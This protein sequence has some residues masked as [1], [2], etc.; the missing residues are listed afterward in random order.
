MQLFLEILKDE[1]FQSGFIGIAGS[2]I[3]GAFTMLSVSWTQKK[4]EQ[5]KKRDQLPERL[6]NL[7]EISVIASNM[8]TLFSNLATTVTSKGKFER[9]ILDNYFEMYKLAAKVDNDTFM[10]VYELEIKIRSALINM[11]VPQ[12][13][14]LKCFEIAQRI[15][16]ELLACSDF[17]E[18]R[19]KELS[20]SYD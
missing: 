8:Y 5:S 2:L 15:K 4:A 20:K 3:G 16:D 7:F 11:S 14:Q 9:E 18:E 17:A 10:R 6:S 13:D 1:K 12:I 19:R